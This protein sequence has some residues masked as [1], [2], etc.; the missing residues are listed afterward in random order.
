MRPVTITNEMRGKGTGEETQ[1]HEVEDY[2]SF[3]E[4]VN[5]VVANVP[6][7]L[8]IERIEAVSANIT[9]PANIKLQF[10]RGGRLRVATGVTVTINS[11]EHIIAGKR[12]YI[13]EEVGTGLVTWT[14][15]GTV[16]VEWW[17]GAGDDA[18]DNTTILQSFLDNHIAG[19]TIELLA[20][21]YR[22]EV[23]GRNTAFSNLT[24]IGK[25]ITKTK[26]KTTATLK[27]EVGNSTACLKFRYAT[28]VFID[29]IHF[30]GNETD[31]VDDGL[32][33][34]MLYFRNSSYN[35]ITNCEFSDVERGLYIEESCYRF[36]ID[37]NIANNCWA[38]GIRVEG[39]GDG[40]RN[41][42]I[43][44]TN[45]L[46]YS[47]GDEKDD[48]VGDGIHLKYVQES[49]VSGN[50]VYSNIL[51]GLR[52]ERSPYNTITHNICRENGASG[53][54]LY[55]A[56]TDY[57]TV[58]GNICINN[59]AN[60][61]GDVDL[62]GS[63]GN[64]GTICG[65][66]VLETADCNIVEG[67]ICN[68]DDG[69]YQGYGIVANLRNLGS[70]ATCSEKNIITHNVA[71]GNLYG[72]IEDRGGFNL[73]GQ[74]QT[75]VDTDHNPWELAI[76]SDRYTAVPTAGDWRAGVY[77]FDYDGSNSIFK[78]TGDGTFGAL[79][80][81]TGTTRITKNILLPSVL[82][83]LAAGNF[84]DVAGGS[85]MSATRLL[86]VPATLASTTCNGASA[87]GQKVLNVTSEAN[88]AVGDTIIIDRGTNDEIGIVWA[89][90]A[91]QLTLQA[92]LAN[93]YSGG[94]TVENVIVTDTTEGASVAGQN[95][96]YHAPTFV[97]V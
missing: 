1:S 71:I 50:I 10:D 33:T 57:N 49:I 2:Q 3:A 79:G 37:N 20:G 89:I 14:N 63:K 18:T 94:E 30:E 29:G 21:T 78:C 5:S 9:I 67:N 45:N 8:Q 35:R 13:F 76:A 56:Y 39:N 88:F 54:H 17:G 6:M 32:N 51:N 69:E 47:N 34:T 27:D 41:S 61:Y 48:F 84:I 72:D 66:I 16:Y 92:N 31:F 15:P 55:N 42:R 43:R 90:A 19:M 80:A 44:I 36:T 96:T 75:K 12:Q 38:V 46:C 86:K 73:V 60:Q 58:Q 74:N 23:I 53:I 95:V 4:A 93:T 64:T 85:S 81:V 77:L 68:N 25:G 65:G 82:T 11:P 28:Y 97:T 7:I 91:G 87:S 70:P 59:N 62:T 52:I 83:G 26:L 22:L 40:S 24:I